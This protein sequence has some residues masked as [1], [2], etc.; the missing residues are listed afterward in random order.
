MKVT[1][2]FDFDVVALQEEDTLT[3]LMAFEA[4]ISE[5]DAARPAECL[6]PILDTSGSMGGSRISSCKQALHT[7]VDRMKPQDIFGLVTFSKEAA[8]HI[9]TRSIGEHD[10]AVV[11]QLIESIHVSGSTDLSAG[12]LLGLDQARRNVQQTGASII[13]LSDGH[14][15]AGITGPDKIG[16]IARSAAGDRITSTTIGIGE[17][18]DETL[19]A[20]IATSGNGSHRFAYTADDAISIVGEEGGDL[21]NKSVINAFLRIVPKDPALVDGIRTLHDTGSWL[22]HTASGEPVVVIP[23]GDIYAGERRELLVQFKLPGMSELGQQ[24]IGDFVVEFVSLPALE[25]SKVTWPITVNVGTSSE[26]SSRVA[27]PTVTTAVL[28]TESAKAQREAS[29]NLRKGRKEEAS[30][31]IQSR[32]ERFTELLAALPEGDESQAARANLQREIDHLNK[33]EYGIQHQE[34]NLMSKSL[35]EESTANLRG[36]NKDDVRRDRARDKRDF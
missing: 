30:A 5:S 12:Y 31:N 6:I 33:L 13:L 2:S 26:A 11:H 35:Y 22:E 8:I 15:N 9:P 28:I 24:K 7:L 14:A 27:D 23:V 29:E 32:V 25:Q 21:L 1:S 34:A 18:Y 10:L 36:R 4:P 20:Q 16:E 17:G 19:L 3:A